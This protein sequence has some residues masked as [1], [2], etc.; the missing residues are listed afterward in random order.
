MAMYRSREDFRLDELIEIANEFIKV[1]APEQPSDRIAETLN[2]R[3][4]RYYIT[5]GLVDRPLGKE[6]TAALYGF[7]HLLQIL[8]VKRLQGS[9]LPIK[10]IREVLAGK[11][12]EELERIVLGRLEEP[13]TYIRQSNAIRPDTTGFG[14]MATPR[15]RGLMLQEPEQGHLL[16]SSRNQIPPAI[17]SLS[18][19]GRSWERFI[20]GDGVELHVRSDRQGNLRSS[21]IRR[22][23]ERILQL[24]K[25]K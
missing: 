11:S 23:V 2:E 3:S 16:E 10:R 18:S 24:L 1:V 12:N 19:P 22:V 9:Y 21:E 4:L 14:W 8:A 17:A 20:L 15:R 6:G 13:M 7:R 25:S 5:E